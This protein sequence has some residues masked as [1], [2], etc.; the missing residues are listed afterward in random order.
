LGISDKNQQ[1]MLQLCRKMIDKTVK[2][3]HV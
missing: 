2:L 1:T 3:K